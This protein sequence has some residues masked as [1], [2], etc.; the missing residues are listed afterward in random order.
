MIDNF[1]IEEDREPSLVSCHQIVNRFFYVKTWEARE[2]I[3]A[4]NDSA[5]NFSGHEISLGFLYFILP[6]RYPYFTK[7]HFLFCIDLLIQ[8]GQYLLKF[9][10]F[11]KFMFFRILRNISRY[12][13]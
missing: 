7:K 11:N 1:E 3:T 4:C 13:H 12:L 8:L 2:T 10:K 5:V 6:C 9:Y